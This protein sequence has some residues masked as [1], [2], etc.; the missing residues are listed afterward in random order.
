MASA[1]DDIKDI[2]VIGVIA[3]IGYLAYQA[4]SGKYQTSPL[5]PPLATQYPDLNPNFPLNLGPLTGGQ[6]LTAQQYQ[7]NLTKVPIVGNTLA[8]WFSYNYGVGGWYGN[9]VI[10]PIAGAYQSDLWKAVQQNPTA[11]AL[12]IAPP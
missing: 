11:A 6:T 10:K 9:N 4:L 2:A 12:R 1:L 8:D 5:P 7:T 3:V